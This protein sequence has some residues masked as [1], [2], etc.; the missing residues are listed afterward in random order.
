[1]FSNRHSLAVVAPKKFAPYPVPMTRILVRKLLRDIR[2]PLLVVG[3]LLF[4]FSFLWVRVAHRVTTEISPYFKL[5]ASL[6]GSNQKDME[7]V[8]FSGV[9]KVSQAVIGG[10]QIRF[11]DPTN[12]LAV[13][14][15]H[16]VIIVLAFLWC[17]G[18]S[19][20]AI[21]G[22][23]ERGTME[24]LLSQPIPRDRLI[25]AH[26]IVDLL[27][28]PLLVS[29][30]LL[31]T[32]L[33]LVASGPFL[34]S[35]EIIDKVVAK[36]P[37]IAKPFIDTKPKELEVRAGPQWTGLLNLTALMFA[38]SGIGIWISACGR[39]RWRATGWAVLTVL[40]MFVLNVIAQLWPPLNPLRP[41]TL[42][43]YYQPHRIWLDGVW[44]VDLGECYGATKGTIL[45][46]G[47][48][49]LF[50]VGSLGY[51]AAWWVF[52]RRDLPAPL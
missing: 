20:G 34:E 49:L 29:T 26:L 44:T 7:E 27:A 48:A 33:G 43:F 24:L 42:F 6:G 14:L 10:D 22:E 51:L 28:I 12:F 21:A 11:D 25:L 18:R 9:G 3:F 35:Q 5:I 2:W 40:A 16:P 8:V 1:M 41:F 4:L 30:I 50:A 23:L 47:T 46:P 32:Q 31:G 17:V 38:M 13:E 45:I 36:A 15:L 39:N 19:G 37:P 52:R